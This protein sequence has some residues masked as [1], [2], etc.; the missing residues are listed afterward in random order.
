MHEGRSEQGGSE[1]EQPGVTG[2][3]PRTTGLTMENVREKLNT[4][5]MRVYSRRLGELAFCEA[6]Y[7]YDD[8]DGCRRKCPLP[9]PDHLRKKIYETEMRVLNEVH[10]GR[11]EQGGSEAEQLGVTGPQPRTT[12]LTMEDNPGSSSALSSVSP[13]TT[14]RQPRTKGLTMEDVRN[15]LWDRELASYTRRL[16]ELASCEAGYRYDD[17]DGCRRKCPLPD[18]EHL[19]REIYATEMRVLERMHEGRSEQGGSEAEHS[20]V[21]EPQPLTRG[22]TMENVRNVLRGRKLAS[23]TRRLRELPS[24]DAGFRYEDEVRRRR[25]HTLRSTGYLR[26]EIYATERQVLERMH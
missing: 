20:G 10:G 2:P 23:Y 4:V 16:G 22:L 21:T 18:P 13:D 3:Q 14:E 7:R 5:E 15:V 25:T 1:A 19:R 8:P 24:C 9:D 17:P 11:S 12:G 26:R 6:G